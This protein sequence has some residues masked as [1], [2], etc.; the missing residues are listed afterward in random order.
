MAV[1]IL[2]ILLI[3]FF[4]SWAGIH[5]QELIYTAALKR[6]LVGYASVGSS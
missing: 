1:N 4:L 6:Q 3:Y 2:I 5:H